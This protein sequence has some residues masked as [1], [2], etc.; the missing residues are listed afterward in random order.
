[1]GVPYYILLCVLATVATVELSGDPL[2][3]WH[4]V[5]IA[6]EYF[7]LLYVIRMVTRLPIQA[8]VLWNSPIFHFQMCMHHILSIMCFGGGLVTNRMHF[9]A[10][11][12][13][14]CEFT[15]VFLT[16]ISMMKWFSPQTSAKYLWANF[17]CGLFL[18]IGF[19]S[20][21]LVLFTVWLMWFY[22]D[23]SSHT[24]MTWDMLTNYER[25]LYPSVTL[26]LLL[27]SSI[28]FVPVTKG[29]LKVFGAVGGKKF[30][31]KA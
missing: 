1:M 14:C 9:W 6:S 18:W 31:K 12:D 21:R 19:L 10:T 8:V 25:Y 28:W 4:G 13:G 5:T 24:T 3:R 15:T 23:I 16:L 30:E 7:Q 29:V 27:L 17:I 22:K 2:S 11:F 26:F 20:H